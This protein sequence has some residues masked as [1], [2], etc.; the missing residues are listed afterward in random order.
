[1]HFNQLFK[2][3]WTHRI[4]LTVVFDLFV[5]FLLSFSP[6]LFLCLLFKY[7]FDIKMSYAHARAVIEFIICSDIHT[8]LLI[9]MKVQ[10]SK[11]F[12][13]LFFYLVHFFFRLSL[14]INFNIE[15][16][17]IVGSLLLNFMVFVAQRL[18]SHVYLLWI[19]DIVFMLR[20]QNRIFRD[21]QFM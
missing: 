2:R 5:F 16:S 4:K 14:W 10:S 8:I 3:L 1:M 21:F 9:L 20:C 15:I 11:I 6:S 19:I 7:C 13:Q 12:S 18:K 17:I